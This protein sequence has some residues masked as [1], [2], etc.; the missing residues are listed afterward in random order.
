M[1][2][3]VNAYLEVLGPLEAF[4]K[5][6]NSEPS[7]SP[8]TTC[9]PPPPLPQAITI[10]SDLIL[11]AVNFLKDPQVKSAPLSKRLAFLEGKG[12]TAEEI[13]LALVR[14]GGRSED[15]VSQHKFKSKGKKDGLLTCFVIESYLYLQKLC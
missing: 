10:R 11:T 1:V 4:N 8:A 6:T 2:D 3:V 5:M 14:A 15:E 7:P 13:D 9:S 12:L